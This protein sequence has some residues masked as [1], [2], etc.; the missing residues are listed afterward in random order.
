MH[1]KD[2]KR[3][4]QGTVVLI[5]LLCV[6]L[7]LAGLYLV[8]RH[9][10]GKINYREASDF[11]GAT[12]LPDMLQTE[13]TP[14]P[15]AEVIDQDQIQ[16][17]QDDLLNGL[18][19][20][21][22]AQKGVYNILLL[23]SDSRLDDYTNRTDTMMLVSINKNTQQ[24]VITSFLRDIY[25]YIPDWGYQRLNVAN[26]AGGPS[27]V[28]Q[29]IQ[30]NFGI[31]I[32]NYAFVNFYSFMDV[33]DILGGIDIPLTDVEVYYINIWVNDPDLQ[34]DASQRTQLEYREDGQYHLNGIQTLAYCRTRNIGGDFGRTQQQ[35]NAIS[36]LWEKARE[37]SVSTLTELLDNI[38]PQITTDVS[39]T[40]CLSILASLATYK[41]YEVISQQVPAE[42][43]YSFV[44]IDGM[45]VLNVDIATN[46]QMLQ[47]TIYGAE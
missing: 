8:F 27:K 33:V 20:D 14:D 39:Q 10:Y 43:T 38:L 13:E 35:R 40:T 3:Q 11:E 21:P 17:I 23:G 41:D 9:F 12:I 4:R 32:D 16:E 37:M 2:K 46:Q 19:N 15:N 24:I 22:I 45:S 44:S 34:V 47:E 25:I 29:T 6:L 18:E 31:A 36:L 26:V 30:Q 7:L 42:G 5:I 1:T 28:I